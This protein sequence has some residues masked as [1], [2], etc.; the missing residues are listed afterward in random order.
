MKYFILFFSAS[1]VAHSAIAGDATQS[2]QACDQAL[3]AGDYGQA[4]SQ[5]KN[6]LAMDANSR[7]AYLC[8]ARA[9][10]EQDHSAEALA[11]L[12]AAEKLSVQPNDRMVALT[13]LGNQYLAG[14]NYAQANAAYAQSLQIARDEKSKLFQ[15]I[16]LN[17]MGAVLEGEGKLDAALENYTQGLALAANDNE[18]ADSHARIAAVQSLL[19][20]HDEAI[21]Q[22]IKSVLYERSS[23]DL[24]HYANAN[25]ELGRIC[26]AGK[27]YA[28]AE[29]WL[30]RFLGTIASSGDS[31]WQA[32][33]RLLLAQVKSAQGAFTEAM[34][35]LTQAKALAQ[36]I[37]AEP[38]MKEI[39]EAEKTLKPL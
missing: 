1:L 37:G 23:G 4:V 22:Q 26:L 3:R 12:Q 8:L 27:K 32:R 18:R 6:A 21:E 29:K 39:G 30:G 17:Q 34:D 11:A 19:G 10:G 2:V 33:A 16:N 35:Q 28:D 9:E 31:Y 14:K 36:K 24:D 38:L 25:I 13:L 20:H 5:A 7:D 15:L